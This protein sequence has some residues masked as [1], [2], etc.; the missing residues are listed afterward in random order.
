MRLVVTGQG[1]KDGKK[2]ASGAAVAV[3]LGLARG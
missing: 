2:L 3:R 1:A